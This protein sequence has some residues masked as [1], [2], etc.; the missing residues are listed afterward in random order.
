MRSIIRNKKNGGCKHYNWRG[1]LP[2][3]LKGGEYDEILKKIFRASREFDRKKRCIRVRTNLDQRSDYT[4][5]VNDH[6]GTHV[7]L[8]IK[9]QNFC[10]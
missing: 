5:E 7:Y 3:K 4:C 8:Y 6:S 2:I 10:F 1:R 9:L